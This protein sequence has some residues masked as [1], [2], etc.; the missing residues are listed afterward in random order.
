V[1]TYVIRNV[2]FSVAGVDLTGDGVIAFSAPGQVMADVVP[3]PRASSVSV[4]GRGNASQNVTISVLK[5]FADDDALEAFSA[6]HFGA[7]VKAGPL[8]VEQLRGGELQ[9]PA[10]GAGWQA[11][12]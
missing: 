4:Y 7:L 5:K 8:V 9:D 3:R 1:A 10:D 12:R 11:Q 2:A 6:G